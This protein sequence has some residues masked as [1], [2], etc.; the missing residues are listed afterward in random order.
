[1]TVYIEKHI[2]NAHTR[3]TC[4]AVLSNTCDQTSGLLIEGKMH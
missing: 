4:W 2:S 3:T 1:M